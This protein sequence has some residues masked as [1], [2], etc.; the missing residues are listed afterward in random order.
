[1]NHYDEDTL[2]SEATAVIGDRETVQGAGMFYP[3][4]LSSAS[5]KG[6]MVGGLAGSAVS[7]ATG[8]LLLETVGNVVGMT[9]GRHEMM[10]QAAADAHLST[11]LIVA[12]TNE[13][14]YVLNRDTSTGLPP[15]ACAFDRATAEVTIKKSGLMR[16]I[17]LAGPGD[18]NEIE[19]R[20][21]TA[22]FNPA[23]KGDKVILAL[24]GS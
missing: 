5:V 7:D 15:I 8:N 18:D 22:V 4:V 13:H 10:D 2:V 17:T 1:M 6:A 19:V 12:V 11:E 16:R 24:L 9:A 21:G 14:I 20:G 3:A 23:A